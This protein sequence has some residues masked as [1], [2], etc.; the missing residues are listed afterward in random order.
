MKQKQQVPRVHVLGTSPQARLALAVT[1]LKNGDY[2]QGISE[3][4]AALN[5]NPHHADIHLTL[6]WIYTALGRY[7][8]AV[9]AARSALKY[10]P[11]LQ[12]GY[13][14]LA[15]SN[16]MLG[17]VPEAMEDCR[18]AVQIDP[19]NYYGHILL[20]ELTLSEMLYEEAIAAFQA[21]THV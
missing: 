12:Q 4:Q 14:I 3:C 1:H 5:T 13:L 19:E 2:Q 15:H 16:K 7:E 8:E 10:N 17:R 6:A 20:G 21:A 18:Q 9:E 11:K